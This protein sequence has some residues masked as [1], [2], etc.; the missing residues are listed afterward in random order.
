MSKT[1]LL[2]WLRFRN[3]IEQVEQFL[4]YEQ[5]I[6]IRQHFVQTSDNRCTFR[7][8]YELEQ[9]ALVCVS[10]HNATNHPNGQ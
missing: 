1:P 5:R 6:I 10:Q 3:L 2:H 7:R 4:S 9:G 8:R